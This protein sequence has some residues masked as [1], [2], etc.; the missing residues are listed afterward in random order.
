MDTAIERRTAFAA[1]AANTALHWQFF[2]AH[3]KLSDQLVYS[4]AMAIRDK[5]RPL[6]PGE[7]GCYS[8]HFDLWT[9]LLADPHVDQYIILEDDVIVDWKAIEIIS[10]VNFQESNIKYMRLY[11]KK[12]G[13]FFLRRPNFIINGRTLI[14]LKDFCFGTQGYVITKSGATTFVASC[15]H[16]TR[17]IDDHMDRAWEH[18]IPNLCIVPFPVIEEAVPSTIG[19]NRFMKFDDGRNPVLKKLGKHIKRA[20]RLFKVGLRHFARDDW[21]VV[22]YAEAETVPPKE[23]GVPAQQ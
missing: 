1:R 13:S 21:R 19:T 4:D 3:R 17:P 20:H 16:V 22:Q 5:G 8:S 14:E 15:R 23:S 11:Y 10:S 2:D 9:R 18:G 12:P 6:Q 7:L